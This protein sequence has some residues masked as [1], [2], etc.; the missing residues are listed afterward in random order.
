MLVIVQT[1]GGK[2]AFK[3]KLIQMDKHFGLNWNFILANDK[4]LA[5]LH[6]LVRT[7]VP[8]VLL[9]LGCS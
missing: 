7:F 3:S 9:D 4:T 2:I 1:S 8:G 6:G 5:V